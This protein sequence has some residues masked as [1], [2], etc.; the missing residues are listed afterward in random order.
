[1][2]GIKAAKGEG[3]TLGMIISIIKFKNASLTMFSWYIKKV[4]SLER[5]SIRVED[6]VWIIMD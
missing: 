4:R 2:I 5:N 6:K 3:T 1:M